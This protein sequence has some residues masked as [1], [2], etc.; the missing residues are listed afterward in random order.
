MLDQTQPTSQNSDCVLEYTHTV[1]Q[2]SDNMLEQTHK[3]SGNSDNMLDRPHP[4]GR[5]GRLPPEMRI[6]VYEFL[7]DRTVRSEYTDTTEAKPSSSFALITSSAQTAI[8]ATCRTI[9]K[10]AKPTLEEKMQGLIDKRLAPGPA[11]H[12]DADPKAMLA[13]ARSG[14]FTA[15]RDYY[16]KLQENTTKKGDTDAI[17]HGLKL[18]I[19][20]KLR[21]YTPVGISREQGIARVLEFVRQASFMLYKDL[22]CNPQASTIP[23]TTV[24]ESRILLV[25]VERSKDVREAEMRQIFD[26]VKELNTSADM[27]GLRIDAHCYSTAGCTRLALVLKSMMH[28]LDLE[29]AWLLRGSI[30]RFGT[31]HGIEVYREDPET[32]QD[33]RLWHSYEWL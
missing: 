16:A 20:T 1:S 19:T 33:V 17:L 13:L 18:T 8:L 6:L 9:Y 3:E 2:N 14:V 11:P 25:V 32:L 15:I 27:L 30:W 28:D 31:L 21:T 12:I 23:T 26:S 5:F 29:R 4:L 10:E 22:L 7:P 24:L